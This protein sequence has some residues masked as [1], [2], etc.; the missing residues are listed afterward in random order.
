MIP[1]RLIEPAGLL[2]GQT[3]RVSVENGAALWLQGGASAFSLCRLGATRCDL[4]L[5]IDRIEPAWQPSL[6]AVQRLPGSAGL[7]MR[8]LVMGIL[9]VTPD[10]FSD[11]GAYPRVEDA[12]VAG[13]AMIEAGADIIDLGGES[14]RPGAE[15]VPASEEQARILPVLRGLCGRGGLISVDTRNA[16]TMRAALDCGADMINDV[17]ALAHDP[18]AADVLAAA[19][20]PVVLMHMRGTP[21]TMRSLARYDDV[22]VE[23]VRELAQ[24]IERAVAAGISRGRIIVDPGIGFAKDEAQNL[25]VLRRLPILANLGCRVMLGASRKRFIGSIAGV[26]VASERGPGSIVASLPVLAFPGCIL[27]VHDVPEM[28]Q[29]L[30]LWQAIQA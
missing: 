27:R 3:A 17:S 15:A 12:V 11:G 30:R 21:A 20:C 28:V 2:H 23:V 19:A 14:T 26:P 18:A 1:P 24:R 29:A 7:P 16:T 9:N 13:L 4:V 8:S 5:P 25:E 10:S 6:Y 22:A